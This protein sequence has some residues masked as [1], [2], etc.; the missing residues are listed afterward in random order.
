MP[1]CYCDIPTFKAATFG[2]PTPGLMGLNTR[3]AAQANPNDTTLQVVSSSGIVHPGDSIY[4]LDG[5]NSEVLMSD[6]STP[7]P[8]TN[9]VKLL[10]PVQ[11]QHAAGISV[12]SPG[13]GGNS[14]AEI[15]LRASTLINNFCRQGTVKD[16]SLF[17]K[18][19]TETYELDTPWAYVDEY[20]S[21][22]MRALWFPINSISS[23]TIQVP[24]GGSIGIATANAVFDV[25]TQRVTFPQV[26]PATGVQIL[27][28]WQLASVPFQRGMQGWLQV[29]FSSGFASN[30]IPDEIQ[31]AAILFTQE[32]LGYAQNPTG[33]AM[34]RRGDVTL[35]QQGRGSAKEKSSDGQYAK[36]AKDL[37]L[38]WQSKFA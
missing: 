38:P 7:A 3:L 8:V 13:R 17:E 18:T 37:L 2:I 10:E 20:Q 11:F 19:R 26:Q 23:A 32:I 21:L 1:D 24:G 9:Q 28:G 15:L 35:M 36:A 33:A 14:L 22:V 30:A 29:T 31:E 12:S 5:A 25:N 6:P 4:L 27:Q 34:I 16:R